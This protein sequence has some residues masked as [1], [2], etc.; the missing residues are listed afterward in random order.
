DDPSGQPPLSGQE[1]PEMSGEGAVPSRPFNNERAPDQLVLKPGTFITVR[2]NQTLSSD[3]NQPGDS[4]SATLVN[5]VVVDG[6]VVAR[7]GQTLGGRVMLAQKAG[8]VEGVSRLTIELTDMTLVDGQQ[9]PIQSQLI[10]RAGGTS[11]GRDAGAI[12]GTSAL[13]AA[14]GA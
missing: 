3:N 13:G 5:P 1:N 6:V 4:F 12:A 7:P 8:R 14:I 10:S 2:V 11:I 9:V